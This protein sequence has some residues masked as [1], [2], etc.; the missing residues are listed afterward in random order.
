MRG[1]G[2][3]EGREG[4][5]E[6]EGWGYG[7]NNNN[8]SL[9]CTRGSSQLC[10][11]VLFLCVFVFCVVGGGTRVRAMFVIFCTRQRDLLAGNWLFDNG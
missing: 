7:A 6:V 4:R 3:G 11:V 5:G 9:V 10:V 2:E 1:L 8:R